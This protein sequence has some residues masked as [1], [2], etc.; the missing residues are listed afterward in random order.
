MQ[1]KKRISGS[2]TSH[3]DGLCYAATDPKDLDGDLPIFFFQLDFLDGELK[4][5][6]AGLIRLCRCIPD[7]RQVVSETLRFTLFA[8]SSNKIQKIFAIL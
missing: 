1:V 5:A 6:F 4:E 3:A 8:E 2:V 7:G